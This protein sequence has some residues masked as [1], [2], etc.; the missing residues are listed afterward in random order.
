M[1]GWMD[2]KRK[3]KKKRGRRGN[4]NGQEVTEITFVSGA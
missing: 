1:D 2:E 3:K 4:G